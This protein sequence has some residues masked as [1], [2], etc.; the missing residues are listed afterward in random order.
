MGESCRKCGGVGH[1][2]RECPTPK[3]KGKGAWKSDLQPYNKGKSKGKGKSD[4]RDFLWQRQK[5]MQR[6]DFLMESAGRAANVVIVLS[7]VRKVSP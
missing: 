2:A 7:I 6:E 3:G 5:Q 4:H 1:Y